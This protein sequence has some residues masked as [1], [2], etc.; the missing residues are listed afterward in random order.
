MENLIV[1][2]TLS[3]TEKCF[4][5]ENIDSKSEYKTGSMLLGERFS[6]QLCYQNKLKNSYKIP[7]HIEVD[8][9][10]ADIISLCRVDCVP[11]RMAVSP[12]S[13]EN[14]LRRE[15]G[16]YP[17]LLR[18]I[19][20][21]TP[22]QITESLASV[23]VD[24]KAPENFKSGEYP[25]DFTLYDDEKNALATAHFD[26]TIINAVLPEQELIFT[27]WFHSD[28]LATYYSE[29]VFSEQHWKIIEN[30]IRA[31]VENGI[32]MILTPVLTPP[33]DTYVGGE[34]P[35]VQLVDI[36]YKNGEWTFG[37]EKLDRW[38]KMCHNAGI[39][40]FEISHLFTQWGAKHSPKVMAHTDNGYE[41]I[42]GWETE[43]NSEEYKNFLSAFLPALDGHLQ[44]LGIADKCR[45]HISDEPSEEDLES[46]KTAKETAQAL[47]KNRIFMDALSDY[48]F[49]SDGVTENPVVATDHTDEFIE[50]G[51]ENLWVYYCCGQSNGVSNRFLAMPTYRTRI[52]GQQLYK[53][54]IEGFLQ[55]GYNFYY[56]QGSREFCNPYLITDGGYWVPA[57]DAFSVYP[58]PDGTAYETIHLLGFTS[59]LSDLRAFRLAEKLIGREK[60]MSV[61]EENGEVTFKEYPKSDSQILTV[62]EKINTLIK[63]NIK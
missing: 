32:N 15:A 16:L 40:Y 21:Q 48:K 22:I 44:Q 11:V 12:S 23:W 5:D 8:S 37:F 1:F 59:A 3:Q 46:Y 19:N 51:V 31:A 54:N 60:V 45:Y 20:E 41:K 26:L 33:L 24:V 53:Y 14:F 61:I 2:K 50:N 63:E 43:A 10:I 6:F 62:R 9:P 34:R 27:Q 18:P 17:D 58:A 42:F 49:Y 57:G 30:F 7:A 35:T 38:V 55:W 39:K 28:C 36:F 29:E 47:L 25:I 13:D 4:L 56:T 52:I